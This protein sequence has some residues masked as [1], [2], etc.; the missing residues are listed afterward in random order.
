MNQLELFFEEWVVCLIAKDGIRTETLLVSAPRR[1][2]LHAEEHAVVKAMCKRLPV[3]FWDLKRSFAHPATLPP[4]EWAEI[5]AK[6][7]S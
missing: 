1:E 4:G 7:S 2:E 5:R 6:S 3:S